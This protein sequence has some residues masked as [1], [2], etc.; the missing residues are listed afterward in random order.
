MYIQIYRNIQR[1]LFIYIFN[2]NKYILY[3]LLTFSSLFIL[4]YTTSIAK[5]DRMHDRSKHYI[6]HLL[7]SDC[8]DIYLIKLNPIN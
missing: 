1:I 8:I 2:N 6:K 4:R 3:F 7:I 5:K